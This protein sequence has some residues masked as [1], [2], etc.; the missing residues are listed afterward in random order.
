MENWHVALLTLGALVV[1]AA[2]PL[3]IQLRSTLLRVEVA[4][5]AASERLIPALEDAR[6]SAHRIR[7]I[8]DELEG[9]EADIGELARSAGDLARTI[10]RLRNTTQVASAVGAAVAA[11]VRAFRE[12]RSTAAE[13]EMDQSVRRA[14]APSAAELPTGGNGMADLGLPGR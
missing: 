7:R 1:G 3:L 9:R 4:V 11:G 8:T 14:A 2:I 6:V 12:T 10:D 5:Q 13:G